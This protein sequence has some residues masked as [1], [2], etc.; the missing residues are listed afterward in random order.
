MFVGMSIIAY[1][2]T[3]KCTDNNLLFFIKMDYFYIYYTAV[4]IYLATV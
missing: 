1:S 4:Y 2:Y 3:L